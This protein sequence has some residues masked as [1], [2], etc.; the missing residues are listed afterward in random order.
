MEGFHQGCINLSCM[1]LKGVL[2]SII[3]LC[4]YLTTSAQYLYHQPSDSFSFNLATPLLLIPND[5]SIAENFI[6]YQKKQNYKT[7]YDQSLGLFCKLENKASS[8]APVN[9]RMRLGSLNYVN[10]LENK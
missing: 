5:N 6:F 8:N 3:F 1:N 2:T 9:L 7:F 10:K 4:S